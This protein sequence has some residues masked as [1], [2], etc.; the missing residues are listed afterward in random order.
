M[1]KQTIYG[2]VIDCE[3]NEQA[4]MDFIAALAFHNDKDICI[5]VERKRKRR[6]LNQNDFMHGPFFDSLHA[7]FLEFGNDY[8]MDLVKSIFK[9]QFGVKKLITL[10]DGQEEYIEIST[11]GYDTKQCEDSMERARRRYAEFWQLPYPNEHTQPP[12]E[13]YNGL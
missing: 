9:K 12:I 1:S 3:L 10:P 6:S 5:T 8:D 11:R 13:A 7:M 2:K 4:A